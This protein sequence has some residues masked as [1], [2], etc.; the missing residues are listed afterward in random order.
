MGAFPEAAPRRVW[1]V[2]PA[3]T[4]PVPA[5]R[6]AAAARAPRACPDAR[7]PA[8][9]ISKPRH[10]Q[11]GKLQYQRRDTTVD[12]TDIVAALNRLPHLLACSRRRCLRMLHA[13][14]KTSGGQTALFRVYTLQTHY[15][16][17]EKSHYLRRTCAPN[18]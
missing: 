14:R 4:R 5:L 2:V 9:A 13:E 11:P 17:L 1:P 10:S 12:D 15:G 3:G 7:L 16:I 18:F 8:G 6:P